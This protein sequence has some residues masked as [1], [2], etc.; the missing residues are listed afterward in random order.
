LTGVFAN[1]VQADKAL[2]LLEREGAE[3]DGVDQAED[4]GVGADSQGE[5]EN[6]DGGEAGVLAQGAERRVRRA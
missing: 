6:G 1:I 3:Q 2:T 5:G 4:G